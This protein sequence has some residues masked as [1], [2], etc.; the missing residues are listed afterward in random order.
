MAGGS[1]ECGKRL[2]AGQGPDG[3]HPY[4]PGVRQ[5]RQDRIVA[6]AIGYRAR[7][8]RHSRPVRTGGK[9]LRAAWASATSRCSRRRRR[10]KKAQSEATL[11][12]IAAFRARA[13][14]VADALGKPY[15]IKHLSLGGQQYRPPVPMMRAAP[16]A[17]ME[18]APMPM[19]AGESQVTATVS[20][21]IELVD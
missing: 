20:G 10:E 21:Q 3:R 1:R 2:F 8:R 12:A 14:L 15:R 17:A 16:M 11:E 4:L 6:H 18:A 7:I 9:A 13:K 5:G 19:E